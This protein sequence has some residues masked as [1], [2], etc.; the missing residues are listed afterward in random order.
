MT[1]GKDLKRHVRARMG[2][3]GES[4]AA[5]RLRVLAKKATAKTTPEPAGPD[6]SSYPALAGRTDEVMRARTGKSWAEWVGA[7]DAIGASAL[8]HRDIARAVMERWPEIGGWWAQSV[9]VGY[10]RIRGL[11]AMGQR[12]SDQSFEAGKSR[13]FAVPVRVLYEAFAVKRR[14]AQWLDVDP[15]MRTCRVDTSARMTWPDATSVIA[16]FVAKG[17]TKSTVTIQ[18]AK[19]AS[20]ED[21][22]RV[23][24]EWSGRLDALGAFVTK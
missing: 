8:S 7:L 12:R 24:R 5:A 11:R 2:E 9:T 14:R 1:K 6:V 21:V 22:A 15:A 16:Y 18:H 10:E 3:T 13:T 4:Y 17:K 20:A 23:K 19:L